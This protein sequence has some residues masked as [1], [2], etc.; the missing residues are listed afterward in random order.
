M[1]ETS[2]DRV[3]KVGLLI[4]VACALWMFVS[5]FAGWY[6]DPALANL[7]FF[8]VLIEIAGLIWG[9]RQTANLGNTYRDQIVAGALM[10]IIAGVII[11][12]ASLLFTMVVFPDAMDALRAADASAT[13]MSQ[14]MAGFLGTLVT[15]ILGSAV[16][17]LWVH[18]RPSA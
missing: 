5:G 17:G 12:G 7:F 13:P 16:I 3:L 2:M 15:G 14:A 9:L 10:S 4:G 18:R 6:K 1:N 11:M 8:V